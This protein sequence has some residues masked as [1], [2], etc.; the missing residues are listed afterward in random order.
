MTYLLTV[1]QTWDVDKVHWK[2]KNQLLNT[3][4]HMQIDNWL[5]SQSKCIIYIIHVL[6]ILCFIKRDDIIWQKS[7][8]KNRNPIF[9]SYCLMFVT[10]CIL[11]RI[12]K[13]FVLV[14]SLDIIKIYFD[15]TISTMWNAVLLRIIIWVSVYII[16]VD[17][18]SNIVILRVQNIRNTRCVGFQRITY[19]LRLVIL[20]G[21]MSS[22]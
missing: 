3:R 11:K 5:G 4:V 12:W 21:L 22:G 1:Y 14:F 2:K 7:W 20:R 8:K 18:N 10:K 6:Y 16:I 13:H 9:P 17:I 15:H 19:D